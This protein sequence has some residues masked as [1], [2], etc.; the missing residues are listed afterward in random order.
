[1]YLNLMYFD[2]DSVNRYMQTHNRQGIQSTTM[3]IQMTSAQLLPNCIAFTFANVGMKVLF[4]KDEY[5]KRAFGKIKEAAEKDLPYLEYDIRIL[6]LG[7]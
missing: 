7:E 2:E 6:Q 4:V 1:M 5:A 3:L